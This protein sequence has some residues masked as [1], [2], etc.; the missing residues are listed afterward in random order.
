MT[1]L[2]KARS[3]LRIADLTPG[4]L[5]RLL[6]LAAAMKED[7]NG[8]HD[9]LAGT[10]VACYFSKPSTRTR[11]SFEAA[12]HRLGGLP[13]MLRPDELQLGRG[14]PIADTARVMSSYC[15][16]IVIRTFAQ[17]DVEKMAAAAS[18]PVINALTDDHH[19]CQALADLLTLRERF[20]DLHGLPVAYV[21][22]GN[23][24][25]HSLIE[26]AMLTGIDL[27]LACPEGY[28]PDPKIA[29]GATVLDSPRE[30]VTGARAVYTDVWVSMGDAESERQRRLDD[31][32]PYGVTPGLMGLAASDAI[33]LHCL[34]AHR[35]E[36]VATAVIDG[37]HS[38]VWQQAANRLPT[39]QAA[40]YALV[41]GDWEV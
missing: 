25:A 6:D 5:H 12:V 20:G 33:F 29:A 9:A 24:V 26:A 8:W 10:S 11:I 4:E 23:N 34:P 36:E 31:L 41:T 32:K 2:T 21:G 28:G 7:P 13:I 40:L 38:A 27:R 30:A 15:S 18:V 14:E 1:T 16:A 3:L 19:P 35:G 22:D 39:E 37:A 17:I